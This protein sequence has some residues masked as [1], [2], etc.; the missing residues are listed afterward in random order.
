MGTYF[1]KHHI[2]PL[3]EW[4]VRIN[5]RANRRN[6]EYNASDNIVWLTLEQHIHVHQ[7]YFEARGIEYDRIAWQ[8]LCGMI[9]KEEAHKQVGIFANTG[10]LQSP[11]SNKK[12]SLSNV[13]HEVTEETRRKIGLFRLG[14][15]YSHISRTR[16]SLAQKGVPK[17]KITCP[18]CNCV[19][20][21]P[22]MKQHHFDNC[23][24]MA[25]C[26]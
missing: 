4:K 23:K 8:L 16:M 17:P 2:I 13:G 10:K 6:K 25:V 7:L 18:R 5:P 3:H 24:K 20:G 1:Y 14:F 21:F 19:G 11:E 22:Q 15:R 9:G 12:R 26:E